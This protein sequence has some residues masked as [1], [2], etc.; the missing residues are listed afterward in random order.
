MLHIRVVI[1]NNSSQISFNNFT[2]IFPRIMSLCFWSSHPL[3][4]LLKIQ[5][6]EFF[7]CFFC[8]I[9]KSYFCCGYELK[10]HMKSYFCCGFELKFQVYENSAYENI[11]T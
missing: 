4:R 10:L 11:W 6:Y 7:I 9:M 8:V 2:V 5:I 3:S 1:A